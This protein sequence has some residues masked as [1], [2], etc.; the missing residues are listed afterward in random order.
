MAYRYVRAKGDRTSPHPTRER[1]I[2]VTVGLIGEMGLDAVE[3]QEIL[4]RAEL[5]SGAL[6]HH[7]RDIPELL[8][9]AMARR[10]PM[11][12]HE[13]IEQ[14]RQAIESATTLAD[15]HRNM[16]SV[17]GASQHPDNRARRAERAHYLALSF[18]SASLRDLIADEQEK[19]TAGMT[20][21]MIDLQERGWLRSG[22]DPKAAAVFV[23]TYTLGRII[24]D[25]TRDPMDAD[26]WN[27]IIRTVMVEAL[28]NPS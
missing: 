26:A 19:I 11:G 25:I 24:D 3:V 8:E 16:A 18:A 23:Q 6:Y 28:S 2:E 22:L 17:I 27:E 7:F 13:S 12:V 14:M 4:R 10:Y 21:V 9:A 20:E 5:S 15:F 1:L